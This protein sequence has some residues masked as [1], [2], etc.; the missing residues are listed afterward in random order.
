M[1]SVAAYQAPLLPNESREAIHL[2]AAQVRT[3][4]SAGVQILC[5]PGA[6]LGGLADYAAQPE[7]MAIDV[8]R[9]QL[10]PIAARIASDTVTTIVG[11]TEI[12]DGRLFNAAA[13]AHKGAVLGVYRKLHPAI[14]KS[15]YEPGSETPVFTVDGLTFGVVICRD[16]LFHEP[17][18]IM[19]KRGAAVLFVP[20]N[21][22]LPPARGGTDVVAHARETDIALAKAH[23]F[24]VVR[25]DVTGHAN[26][27]VSYGSSDIVNHDGTVV[28]TAKPF[29]VGLI[30]AEVQTAVRI[31]GI[32]KFTSV[33]H[34]A[35]MSRGAS[36]TRSPSTSAAPRT[37]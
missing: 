23:G 19:A 1:I 8:K 17:A 2:I 35:G 30:V 3:C 13:V 14:N 16:S 12:D 27:L 36:R 4:E 37:G 26:G 22:G 25:A 9:G 11:F 5:C 15:I 18:S 20:T 32:P 28:R 7:A 10:Q 6:V 21:N 29:E 31:P 33:D 24:A 34:G